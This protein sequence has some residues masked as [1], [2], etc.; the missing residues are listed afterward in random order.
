MIPIFLLQL[1]SKLYTGLVIVDLLA[2][3]DDFKPFYLFFQ[4]LVTFY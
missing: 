1:F 2:V 3:D 4:L